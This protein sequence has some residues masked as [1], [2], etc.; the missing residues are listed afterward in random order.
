MTPAASLPPAR[1]R[2]TRWRRRGEALLRRLRRWQK[3]ASRARRRLARSPRAVRV[4]V[5]VATLLG[6]LLIVLP[7]ANIVY[8]VARKPAEMFSP[9]S[10]VLNKQPAETW[11]QYGPLFRV[12][13]TTAVSAEVLAALAQSESAGNPVARTYWRWRLSWNPL[14][15]YRPAS[16]AVGMFQMT[17]AAFA[18]SRAF[19]IRD[20][21]VA[22]DGCWFTSLYTRT[23]PSHAVELTAVYLTRHAAILLGGRPPAKPTVRQ[24]QD[25]AAFIHLCGPGAARAFV[26]RGLRLAPGERCGDHDVAVYLTRVETFRRQFQRLAETD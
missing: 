19:C 25:L 22:R 7:V 15:I 10:G 12:H 8:Q 24:R 14:E 9:L 11:R 20:G 26:R 16:S 1:R 3:A 23:I 18:E 13:A 21:T 6:G 17:D 2:K 5:A 4:A